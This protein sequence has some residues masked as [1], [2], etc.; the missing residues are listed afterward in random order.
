METNTPSTLAEVMGTL[1]E[2]AAVARAGD[3]DR[4][5]AALRLAE[6]QGI[7]A[8]QTKDACQWGRRR[9]PGAAGELDCGRGE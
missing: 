2:L 6:R 9:G 1:N 5:R 3:V 7:T 4:Y 8:E